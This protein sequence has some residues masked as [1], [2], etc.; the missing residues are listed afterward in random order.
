MPKIAHTQSCN[1]LK[2][3]ESDLFSLDLIP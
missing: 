3:S 1:G 2:F